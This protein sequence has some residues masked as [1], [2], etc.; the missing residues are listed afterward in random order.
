ML[1]IYKLWRS[2]KY[3]KCYTGLQRKCM[4]EKWYWLLN[5]KIAYFYYNNIIIKN[6][7]KIF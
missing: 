5:Y 7:Y 1:V 2:L 6:N 4:S 3:A